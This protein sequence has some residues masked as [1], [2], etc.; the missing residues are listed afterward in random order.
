V[1]IEQDN[2]FKNPDMFR[3][4][5]CAGCGHVGIE[6]KQVGVL[7]A[8]RLDPDNNAGPKTFFVTFCSGCGEKLDVKGRPVDAGGNPKPLKPRMMGN[9][10]ERG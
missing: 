3:P 5:P 1:K 2:P 4:V 8:H 10:G 9:G 6:I 7:V